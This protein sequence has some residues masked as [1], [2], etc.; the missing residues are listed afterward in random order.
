M[1]V[2]T[3]MSVLVVFVLFNNQEQ[4]GHV[5]DNVLRAVTVMTQTA[6]SQTMLW[7]L[8]MDTTFVSVFSKTRDMTVVS[9]KPTFC[10]TFGIVAYFICTGYNSAAL[11]IYRIEFYVPTV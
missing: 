2:T 1:V 8:A 5:H 3:V 7:L 10:V 9:I 6:M 11:L 4:D